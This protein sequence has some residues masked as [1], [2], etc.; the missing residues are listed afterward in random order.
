[1][2]GHRELV[3]D[4]VT[5]FLFPAGEAEALAAVLARVLDAREDWPRVRAAARTFVE[6]ERTWQ[7]SVARYADA[8]A[9]AQFRHAPTQDHVWHS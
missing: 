7:R 4:G 5:G 2:G 1:V 6:Q 9:Q 3:R 8:Y